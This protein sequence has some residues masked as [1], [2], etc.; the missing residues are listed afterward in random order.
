MR[1]ADGTHCNA[2][3]TDLRGTEHDQ[4]SR[5]CYLQTSRVATGYGKT[6]QTRYP[7][8]SPSGIP[9]LKT[10]QVK[11]LNH[12]SRINLFADSEDYVPA[13]VFNTDVAD[14]DHLAIPG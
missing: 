9:P 13:S 14:P 4:A 8:G 3:T 5:C 12:H 10:R 11:Q 1:D 6:R 7:S 2:V